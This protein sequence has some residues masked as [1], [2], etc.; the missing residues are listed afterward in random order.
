MG[1]VIQLRDRLPARAAT[2]RESAALIDLEIADPGAR[3]ALPEPEVDLAAL[4][5]APLPPAGATAAL[6]R[7][8]EAEL[9][10]GGIEIAAVAVDTIFIIKKPGSH[11]ADHEIEFKQAMIGALAP[12]SNVVLSEAV[13]ELNNSPSEWVPVAGVVVQLCERQ[14]ARRRDQL[15]AILRVEAE[16]ERRH[17]A[18]QADAERRRADDAYLGRLAASLGDDIAPEDFGLAHDL[19]PALRRGR[20]LAWSEAVH[21]T[22]APQ[23]V[24]QLATIARANP[25]DREGAIAAACEAAGL[26]PPPRAHPARAPEIDTAPRPLGE[27]LPGAVAETMEGGTNA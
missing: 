12:Y 9:E 22:W 21:K 17:Q 11:V 4:P 26:D 25:A 3:L 7:R 13:R 2:A 27:I 1:E 19:M 6:Q 8:L 10:P 23:L 15:H 24:R 16:R 5:L 20:A 18:E 14:V